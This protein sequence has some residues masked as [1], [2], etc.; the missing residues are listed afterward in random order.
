MKKFLFAL[1]ISLS[2]LAAA[3]IHM[4]A[5]K[6]DLQTLKKEIDSGVDINLQNKKYAQTAL[7]L[8]VYHERFDAVEYLLDKGADTNVRMKNGQSALFT[9][10][11][12]GKNRMITSLLQHGAVVNIEDNAGDTPLHRAAEGGHPA[13]I[14]LLIEHGAKVNAANK[15]RSTP[16]HIAAEFNNEE[17]VW[18]LLKGG[19]SNTVV[20]NEGL[21]ASD[22]AEEE[23]NGRIAKIIDKYA[24]K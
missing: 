8:A 18:A 20:D 7:D 5:T 14:R 24:K 19:A 21:K 22:V 10:A 15:N 11:Y 12:M 16:L 9:A 2:A 4:A 13:A 17:A 1:L 3:T 23:E 6:G